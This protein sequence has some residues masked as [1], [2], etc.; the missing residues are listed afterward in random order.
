MS[1]AVHVNRTP[2]ARLNE[3]VADIGRF[4]VTYNLHRLPSTMAV[5]RFRKAEVHGSSPWV[6]SNAVLAKQD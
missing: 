1:A 3:G 5:H 6:G 4:V 2:E